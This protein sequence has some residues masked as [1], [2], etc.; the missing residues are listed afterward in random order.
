MCCIPEHIIFHGANAGSN[1]VGQHDTENVLHAFRQFVC[2]LE[3]LP[4]HGKKMENSKMGKTMASGYLLQYCHSLNLQGYRRPSLPIESHL[5]QLY[6]CLRGLLVLFR[7]LG[8]ILP[9]AVYQ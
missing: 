2:P 5:S 4:L 3:R 1:K 8:F 7:L 6:S 9:H